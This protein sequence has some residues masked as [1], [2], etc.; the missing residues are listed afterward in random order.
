[1]RPRDSSRYGPVEAP[2]SPPRRTATGRRYVSTDRERMTRTSAI[3]AA[4]RRE[5]R[6]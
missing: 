3:Q 5:P 2:K 1:V 6:S 4:H